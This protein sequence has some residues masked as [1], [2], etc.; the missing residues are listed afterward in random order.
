M[1]GEEPEELETQQLSDTIK[2]ARI[3]NKELKD[4]IM[5]GEIKK[6]ESSV[7]T[8]VNSIA[9]MREEMRLGITNSAK[10][11]AVLDER[12]KHTATKADVNVL[13]ADV[14]VLDERLEHTAT[15]ADVNVLDERLKHTAT[16]AW[17]R[18]GI[19]FIILSAITIGLSVISILP[20]LQPNSPHNQVETESKG[21]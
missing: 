13:K 21:G 3:Q 6:L 11:I 7:G 4:Q 14:N 12:L 15:K 2:S 18:G 16:K 20:N 10:Q 5:S 17:V 1:T 8:L 19:I 9:D